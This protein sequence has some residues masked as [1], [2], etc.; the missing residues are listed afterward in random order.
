[1]VE[2]IEKING[3]FIQMR[4]SEHVPN[5]FDKVKLWYLL[6]PIR[7]GIGFPPHFNED[8]CLICGRPLGNYGPRENDFEIKQKRYCPQCDNHS[9]PTFNFGSRLP[10]WVWSDVLFESVLFH[11]DIDIKKFIERHARK[12]K[13][14]PCKVH[15][16]SFYL[17]RQK[18]N[19]ILDEAEPII[20]RYLSKRPSLI[21]G[22]WVMDARY[23]DMPYRK[24]RYT[25][26]YLK[27]SG[28]PH[29]NPI[30]VA[31][32]AK[33]YWFALEVEMNQDTFSVLHALT[34]ALDRAGV[35]PKLKI[36]YAK[37]QYAAAKYVLSEE[38]KEIDRIDKHASKEEYGKMASCERHFSDL[39]QRNNK[40]HCQR[41][42][43]WT[44]QDDLNIFRWYRNYLWAKESNGKTPAELLG[45]VLPSEVKNPDDLLPLVKFSYRLTQYV[46]GEIARAKSSH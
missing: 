8:C 1:M 6:A 37:G 46:K 23:N 33:G 42:K 26:K 15:V 19:S 34:L 11:K 44:L 21:R 32:E 28:H 45:I 35:R 39:G 12:D 22:K 41:R 5:W 16:Q 3:P 25:G 40:H 10:E 31:H 29:I 27:K 2:K 14:Q 7:N 9:T 43:P 24:S 17:I 13:L 20:L 4:I 18:A 36:D 30:M 38:V